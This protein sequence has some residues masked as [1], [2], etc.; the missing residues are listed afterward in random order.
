MEPPPSPEALYQEHGRF[1]W[2]L[3]YRMTGSTADADDVVQE[4]FVR[5]LA[6]EDP[7]D[8]MRAW[9]TRIALNLAT[10]VLRGRKRDGY[11]GPWLPSPVATPEAEVLEEDRPEGRYA[12]LESVSFA[13]LLALEQ[14]GERE[15]AVL[16]L[17]NVFDYSVREAADLL[18]M[19]ES[20]VKTTHHRARASLAGYDEVRATSKKRAALTESALR[21]FLGALTT[22]DLAAVEA[23][24]APGA[25]SLSDGGGQLTAARVPV[26]G[27]AKVAKFY[28][29]VSRDA[30][31]A[32]HAHL[33]WMNGLPALVLELTPRKE[34]LASRF[35]M[36]VEVD[37]EGRITT[38]YSQLATR[39]LCGVSFR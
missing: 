17:R 32:V 27:P 22:R 5:A 13:F 24:L 31:E 21:A 38:V 35:V 39:K 6:R 1:L 7:K 34:P 14:L 23:L 3:S 11:V 10:D 9:L 33:E 28:V 29:N 8:E 26:V 30:G 25:R 18:E 36:Q 15:R 19:T 4:T 12:M 37:D 16:L 2:A 20:N